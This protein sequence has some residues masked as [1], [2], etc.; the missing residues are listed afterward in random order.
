VDL[1]ATVGNFNRLPWSFNNMASFIT[2]RPVNR[3]E[4]VNV[5]P[6]VGKVE[7]P[8]P[9]VLFHYMNRENGETYDKHQ[10]LIP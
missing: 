9:K 4:R 5:A 3:Y 6:G 7:N 1:S 2:L 8:Y 10:C